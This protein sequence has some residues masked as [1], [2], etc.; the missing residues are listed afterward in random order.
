M[1]TKPFK[2]NPENLARLDKL[3][4]EL[5]ERLIP[6]FHET[7]RTVMED[8][9]ACAATNAV[10]QVASELV[11]TT[12]GNIPAARRPALIASFREQL[13]VAQANSHG[14]S[15]RA[16]VEKSFLIRGYRDFLNPIPLS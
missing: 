5:V 1:R 16:F 7:I 9:N 13:Q 2:V 12:L 10:F 6:L 3:Q 11:L 4:G 8:Q 14:P 15:L